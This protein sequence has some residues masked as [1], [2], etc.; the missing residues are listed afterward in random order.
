MNSMI[1][2]Y[3]SIL[4]YFGNDEESHF[5]KNINFKLYPTQFAFD[6]YSGLRLW[7]R[8]ITSGKE[9]LFLKIWSITIKDLL[10][11]DKTLE[12]FILDTIGIV[13]VIEK[14]HFQ[15]FKK[16]WNDKFVNYPV[17]IISDFQLN[18]DFTKEIKNIRFFQ[19]DNIK[20][21]NEI[22]DILLEE[23]K[24]IKDLKTIYVCSDC[25]HEL[26]LIPDGNFRYCFCGKSGINHSERFTRLIGRAI[27][28]RRRQ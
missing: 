16:F 14:T 6:V 19:I 18:L 1:Q 10:K 17:L 21:V 11:D 25:K 5:L 26:P 7:G 28:I 2:K 27:E 9:K 3:K 22:E 8:Y 23:I 13:I 20:N 15:E 12:R 4:F 24:K